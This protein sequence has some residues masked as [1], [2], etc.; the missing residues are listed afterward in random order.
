VSGYIVYGILFKNNTGG[1]ID[2]VTMSYKAE[3]WRKTNG[4]TVS[5]RVKLGYVIEGEIDLSAASLLNNTAT[6]WISQGDMITID[7]ASSNGPVNGNTIF[8]QIN[9]NFPVALGSGDEIF[10]RFFDENV[11]GTDKAMAVDDLRISFS[12]NGSPGARVAYTANPL[13]KKNEEEQMQSVTIY[14]SMGAILYSAL[15]PKKTDLSDI[16]YPSLAGQLII[17]K[18]VSATNGVGVKKILIAK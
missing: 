8:T 9:I 17:I 14:N 10:I 13:E 6:T 2:N 1:Q 5:Q 12:T 15:V 18:T 11:A 16:Y 3:Q 7:N 4:T